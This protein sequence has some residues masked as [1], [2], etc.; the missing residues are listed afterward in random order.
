MRNR[1]TSAAEAVSIVQSGDTT[2]TSGF[3]GVGTPNEL[4]LARQQRF[5]D[6]GEPRDLTLV[7]GTGQGD[8]K[9]RRGNAL[10]YEGLL[11]RVVAAHFG[12][13]PRPVKLAL[14]NK[15]EA[16]NLPQGVIAQMYRDVAAGKPRTLSRAGIGAFVDPRNEGG[17]V[18]AISTTD[19]MRLMG[20]A[21]QEWLFFK[22]LPIQVAILRGTSADAEG[23]V[24]AERESLALDN[25]AQAMAAKNSGG[26]VIVQV[27]RIAAPRSLHARDLL[28][29]GAL[30]ECVV[31]AQPEN[32]PQTYGTAYNTA[33]SGEVKAS[34]DSVVPM[35]LDEHKITARH[36]AMELRAGAIIHQNQQFDFYDGGSLD[37][38]F[39][40]MAET[41][42]S[43][44]VNVSRFG[45]RM[46]GPGGFINISQNAR[47][48]VFSGAFAAGGLTLAVAAGKVAAAA[49]KPVLY[50]TERC[51]FSLGTDRLELIEV[52]PGIDIERDALALIPFRPIARRVAPMDPSIF[53]LGS[54]GLKAKLLDLDVADHIAYDTGRDTLF[55]DFEGL[56]LRTA[57]E[58]EALHP[59]VTARCEQIG[60]ERCVST[61]SRARPRTVRL[62]LFESKTANRA[63]PPVREQD[64]CAN[65]SRRQ[66][67]I[68]LA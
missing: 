5:L 10:G 7:Y 67:M 9:G 45:S 13:S 6:S 58:L 24:S 66:C 56:Q 11:K 19:L 33:C 27:E 43:G 68:R 35:A 31:A 34:M 49:G 30:V 20:I 44:N 22:A 55:L 38:A 47:K 16:F 42:V 46:I 37:L 41:D 53:Q 61:C 15:I 50:I 60:R 4:L 57:A 8:G 59:A 52:A 64:R 48:V 23:N 51:V 36:C 29:P 26:I 40:G 18:N 32:H 14:D 17:K 3:V 28:I 12:L 39:L 62:H 2:T 25:P 65:F 21:G 54:M 63:S 1:I